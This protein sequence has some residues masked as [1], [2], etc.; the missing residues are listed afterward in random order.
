MNFYIV[1]DDPDLLVLLERVL[2]SAGHEVQTCD[3][4]RRALVE[5]PIARPDCVITDLMM[6]EMDGFELT[7]EL[8]RRIELSKM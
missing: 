1:D 3:S 6:P 4:S 5:I 7:R 8:R 2:K